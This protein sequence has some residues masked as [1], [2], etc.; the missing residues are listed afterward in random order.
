M[1]AAEA[2]GWSLP[3]RLYPAETVWACPSSHVSCLLEDIS[4]GSAESV[5]GWFLL[6]PDVTA[7]QAAAVHAGVRCNRHRG[8]VAVTLRTDVIDT[9]TDVDIASRLPHFATP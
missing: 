7:I 3:Q 1:I 6:A 9:G 2:L 8:F 5:C 4:L